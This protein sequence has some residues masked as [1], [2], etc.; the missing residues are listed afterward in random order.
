MAVPTAPSG[1]TLTVLSTTS[2]KAAWTDNANNEDFYNVYRS[3]DGTTY[4]VVKKLNPN[5]HS[6]TDTGLTAGTLY[7]YKVRCHGAD[8][9]SSYCTAASATTATAVA[10]AAPTGQTTVPLSGSEVEVNF[11]NASVGEDYHVIYRKAG[12]GAYAD[13]KQLATGTTYYLDTGL[14]AGTTYTYKIRDL[15]G[16]ATYGDYSSETTATPPVP[17]SYI[18]YGTGTT[19]E[20]IALTALATEVERAAATVEIVS[21]YTPN[22]TVR[23]SHEFTAAG[24]I[25]ATEV[26]VFNDS[27]AGTMLGRKLVN[28]TTGVA[29]VS[30]QNFL[31]QYD[32]IVKDGGAGG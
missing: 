11:T 23:F 17:F 5:A 2:I 26:G 9:Y 21:T 16:T 19:A 14:T 6:W 29:L 15:S 25:S 22:D 1:I 31:A 13:I 10:L 27:T 32:F 12:S 8:G 28:G 4:A 18:A 7:Y 20:G 3:L 30:Q 24:T